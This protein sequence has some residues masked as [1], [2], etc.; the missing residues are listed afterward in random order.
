MT[1]KEILD[2]FY[3]FVTQQENAYYNKL[4]SDASLQDLVDLNIAVTYQKDRY[5]IDMARE[6]E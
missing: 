6:G 3:D 2:S 5:A 1:G 4:K